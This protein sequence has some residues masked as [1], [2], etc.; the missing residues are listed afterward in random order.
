MCAYVTCANGGSCRQS[1]TPRCFACDCPTGYLGSIC[2]TKETSGQSNSF[3][4][5]GFRP[6]AHSFLFQQIYASWNHVYKVAV[7][8]RRAIIF[9]AFVLL[10]LRD[11]IV[12]NR[13]NPIHVIHGHVWMMVL[14]SIRVW[15]A[16]N[17]SVPPTSLVIC[18]KTSHWRI[19]ASPIHV[20][21]TAVASVET[22]HS[23]VSVQLIPP[24]ITARIQPSTIF[25]SFTPVWMVG[26]LP[27][28]QRNLWMHLSGERHWLSVWK[29][30]TGGS[31]RVL[32]MSQ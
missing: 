5:K 20:S 21:I 3:S 7:V 11:A 8:I 29:H 14:A 24:A 13:Y 22:E 19:P 10:V 30:H 23:N 17:V 12:N 31:L 2:Q 6:T 9:F 4:S 26:Q 1:N 16:L 18:V 32:S 15:I 27:E 25:A 28:W